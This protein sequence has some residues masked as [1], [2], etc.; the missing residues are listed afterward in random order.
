MLAGVQFITD[1]GFYP[2]TDAQLNR[3]MK[4]FPVLLESLLNAPAGSFSFLYEK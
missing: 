3:R 4:A 1:L 2:W